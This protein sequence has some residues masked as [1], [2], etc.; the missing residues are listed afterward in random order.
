MWIEFAVGNCELF[1]YSLEYEA[2]AF[3]HL[4]ES[5]DQSDTKRLCL[6]YTIMPYT[7]AS[8]LTHT[9]LHFAISRRK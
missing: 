1:A 8:T 6:D 2:F 9:T 7:V 3:N 5:V 4:I